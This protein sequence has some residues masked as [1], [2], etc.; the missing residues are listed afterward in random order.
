MVIPIE[1]SPQKPVSLLGL[2]GKT[3]ALHGLGE[4]CSGYKIREVVITVKTHRVQ[5]E[6]VQL[7]KA[8]DGLE[9]I[10]FE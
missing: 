8:S 10:G 9:T 4:R 1:V 2:R 5:G 7:F 3:G 6:I